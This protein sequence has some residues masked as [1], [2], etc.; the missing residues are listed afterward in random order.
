MKIAVD[1]DGVLLDIMVEY[2][3]IFNERYGTNYNK[4]DVTDWE[5]FRDWNIDVKIAFEIFTAIYEDS[6]NV[7]F[8]DEDSIE[9]MQKLNK[10]QEVFIVTARNPQYKKP[11]VKKLSSH[12]IKKGIQYEGIILLHHEP[13]DIKLEQ[14]FDVYIDDNPNLVESIKLFEERTLLLF[15]Q[16]W[17][18]KS[19]CEK[20]V[21]RVYNWKDVYR[22]I[23]ELEKKKLV[24]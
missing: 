23:R 18:Q 3:K 2:C 17:N 15:D 19:K 20:N 9:I 4:K 22:K 8:I 10:D 5:F 1:I 6:M 12:N 7:P 16:P 21:I 13:Y 24:N 11:V 14:H